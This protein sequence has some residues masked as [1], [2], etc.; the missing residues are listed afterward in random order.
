MVNRFWLIVK[1]TKELFNW[2]FIAWQIGLLVAILILL[3]SV[4]ISRFKSLQA[5]LPLSSGEA[6]VIEE[7]LPSPSLLPSAK[8]L[9]E[10]VTRIGS[11]QTKVLVSSNPLCKGVTEPWKLIP[12][13]SHEGEYVICNVVPEKMTTVDEL[14]AAQNEYRRDQGLNTLGIDA[15]LC[16]VAG[17]RA[18]EISTNFS[19]DGFEAAT[20]RNGVN[21][22][23][24]GEN[25]ASGPLSGVHFVQWAWDRSPGHRDNML[26]DWNAGCGGVFDRFAVFI[27]AR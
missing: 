2:R 3:T 26:R 15:T 6:P 1:S 11:S 7:S 17:Q 24:I 4:N 5:S 12:D 21:R 8:N 9:P 20:E 23:A 10:P 25:I 14:N 16:A 18:K 13:P 19:H 27:F 22:S